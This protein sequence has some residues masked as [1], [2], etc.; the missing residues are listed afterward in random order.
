MNTLGNSSALVCA[1]IRMWNSHCTRYCNLIV[2]AQILNFVFPPAPG[3]GIYWLSYCN[4]LE[5][6]N[7]VF[8]HKV[9]GLVVK[10]INSLY[11]FGS[12][13]RIR[14]CLIL[15][16]ILKHCIYHSKSWK[17]NLR[18]SIYKRSRLRIFFC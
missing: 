17:R 11:K 9:S 13:D 8:C 6:S 2:I 18:C 7:K 5:C 15:S 14:K 4:L 3:T 1:G 10:T 16:A 12:P